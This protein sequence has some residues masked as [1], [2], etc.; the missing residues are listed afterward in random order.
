MALTGLKPAVF[1]SAALAA[2]LALSSRAA[3][4]PEIYRLTLRS[5]GWVSTEKKGRTS[6]ATCW[7][8]DR[9]R[10][11]AVTNAHV[12]RGRQG[13]H[14]VSVFFPL[15]QNGQPVRRVAVYRQQSEGIPAQV[16]HTDSKRDLALLRLKWVPAGVRPLPLADHGPRK[17]EKIFTVGNSSI[18]S[19]KLWRFRKGTII[20]VAFHRSFHRGRGWGKAVFSSSKP[21]RGA[22]HF[23]TVIV[24]RTGS[25]PGDSGGP[26]VNRDGEL[27][28]VHFAG[29]RAGK[30]V[31]VHV[32]EVRRFL[33]QAGD[34]G[35][36]ASARKGLFRTRWPRW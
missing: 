29:T 7:L 6:A 4:H 1:Y 31:S 33:G 26:M 5:T 30:D 8:L 35:P 23:K 19:G 34:G 16:I 11:L 20:R 28:G 32:R 12:V 13:R 18:G 21:A 2:F 9:E 25:R 22:R 15:Y 17:G 10:R 24:A 3:A 27:V 14:S 36:R